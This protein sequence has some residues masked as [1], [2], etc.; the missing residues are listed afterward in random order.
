M[1]RPDAN[2]A[3][4]PRRRPSG[5]RCRSCPSSCSS[6]SLRAAHQDR[7]GVD[8]DRPTEGSLYLR[9]FMYASEVFL[10][11]RPATEYL[12]LVIAS[13]VGAVL[14]RRRQAGRACGS[15][16]DYTRAAPG[17]TGAAKC[18]GNYAAGLSA[19][20]EAI[21]HGCDQVVFLDAV[22]RKY[23]DELGGMNIFFVLR[24]RQPGH[25][26]ADRHDPARHHPRLGHHAG[27]ARRAA[28]SRSGRSASTSG[29]PTP[30]AAGSARRSPAA[31][32]R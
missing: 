23:V 1:F 16:P 5:W 24:R 31:R 9:P 27:R 32:P 10:G 8:P 4:V 25:P 12:Y 15:P 2:A 14:R 11:V 30:R 17:G 22:E 7:P 21:E 13:P 18:G 29:A 26:A 20:A 3:P 28:R 6:S 19:Q